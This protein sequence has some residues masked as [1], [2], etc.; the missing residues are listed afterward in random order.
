MSTTTDNVRF[1]S[2]KTPQAAV[3]ALATMACGAAAL[4]VAMGWAR[5]GFGGDLWS[6]LAGLLTFAI[7]GLL[8][9]AINVAGD[10][11]GVE[12]KLI[13]SLLLIAT[14]LFAFV[15]IKVLAIGWLWSQFWLGMLV[16][17]LYAV[18]I[19]IHQIHKFK[20]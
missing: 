14:F 8:T 13:I 16:L 10:K 15:V 2:S 3:A 1:I 5:I 18:A 20:S 6:F 11:T 7:I 19:T 12:S 17:G 9:F 4:Y